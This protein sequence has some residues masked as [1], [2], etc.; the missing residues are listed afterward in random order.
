MYT[1]QSETKLPVEIPAS[2]SPE[3]WLVYPMSNEQPELPV[4]EFKVHVSGSPE[5]GLVYFSSKTTKMCL[6]QWIDSWQIQDIQGDDTQDVLKLWIAAQRWVAQKSRHE[7]ITISESEVPTAHQRVRYL[8]GYGVFQQCN[9]IGKYM[10]TQLA[11]E[12]PHGLALMVVLENKNSLFKTLSNPVLWTLLSY[13]PANRW[14]VVLKR[15][16]DLSESE[17]TLLR[18]PAPRAYLFCSTF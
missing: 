10:A 17:A 18:E 5:D 11:T 1:A 2:G 13:F 15:K 16:A 6:Y 14:T 3:D 7:A 4:V 12:T 9:V 8:F